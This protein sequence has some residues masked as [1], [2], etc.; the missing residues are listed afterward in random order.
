MYFLKKPNVEKLQNQLIHG[1]INRRQFMQA[2]MVAG[3]APVA[4]SMVP[5]SARAAGSDLNY[6]TWS[7]YEVPELHQPYIDEHGSSPGWSVFASAEDGLQKIRAGF[8]T[9]LSHPC[10]DDA[11]KW[12]AAGVIQPIDTSRVSYWDDMFP[13]LHDMTGAVIDNDVY[14][15]LTDFG[16]SS[17]IY[18]TD[19]Y[20]GEE[21]WMMLFDE[22]F[23][24]RI[25]ARGTFVNLSI[26]LKILGYDVFE[27]TDAQLA[28]AGDLAR[29]Q[30]P[31]VRFYWES[32]TDMEQAI[33]TGECFAG[34]AWNEALVNLIEQGVPVAFAA[35][36]EGPFGW[37]C[38]LTYMTGSEADEGLVYDFIDA[39]LSPE[40]GKFLIETYG[41]G[42]G[43]RKSFDLVD[44]ETLKT[45]GYEDPIA[46]M[47]GTT[48][49]VPAS[50]ESDAKQLQLW[51]DIQAGL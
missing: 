51:E 42:H 26:A 37:A 6:F 20:D 41:Y 44:P 11:P 19:M 2:S 33:A 21:T 4:T 39:W 38:G 5:G 22:Q 14:M 30:R 8:Q 7:G 48:F 1:R 40:S 50:P 3:L 36:K 49:F 16:L 17:I 34:Y 27:P 9:D 18:R 43:N 47:D 13:S 28:E 31:L 12:Q 25:C 35:P 32:Q 46:L 29:A 23:A 45:L 15:I 24:G 10:V